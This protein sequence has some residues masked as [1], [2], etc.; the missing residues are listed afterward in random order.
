MITAFRKI[1]NWFIADILKSTDDFYDK[2]RIN[3]IF[4]YPFF[5]IF[6]G[7][8]ACSIFFI[9]GQKFSY[10]AVLGGEAFCVLLL[11]FLKYSKNVS[12][13][14]LVY[15]WGLLAV[16]VLN[17]YFNH[18][19]L[20]LGY[21]FWLTLIILLA[22]F[23]LNYKHGLVIGLAGSIAFVIYRQFFLYQ[24][25]EASKANPIE[26][27][28]AFMVEL[29][30]V[31]FLLLYLI[32]IYL[33]TSRKSETALMIKNQQLQEKN[34]LIQS[35][36]EEKTI[37]LR[38]IH[39]RVK[40][41]LQVIK[42][43][44]RL[45]SM[46]IE[47][48]KIQEVFELSQKRIVAMSLI[49]ERLYQL[50]RINNEISPSYLPELVKDLIDLYSGDQKI[51]LEIQMDYGF[52][53]QKNIVPFGL[54]VNELVSNSL[55]HGINGTGTITILGHRNQQYFNFSYADNGKG[56]SEDFKKS[57]GMELI[58][59]LTDQLDGTLEIHS[60]EK[61]GTQFDFRFLISKE[62]L[63]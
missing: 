5:M 49:H 29:I 24:G 15:A 40:N 44:L 10:A 35:Q 62:L 54:V 27:F 47:D 45:Q 57:F 38:E 52:I 26:H 4:D 55:K 2:A 30:I 46:D 33:L 25:M 58:D 19:L 11:F 37:M 14:S 59:S 8:I 60:K 41:N 3:L 63:E 39:H 56:L 32:Y 42:S 7:T 9:L 28:G 34:E 31:L 16:V 22:T 61:I 36:S 17:L 51:K 18:K 48:P 13:T 12:I 20:H 6:I 21:P 1:K 53:N 23:N 43:I 50:E